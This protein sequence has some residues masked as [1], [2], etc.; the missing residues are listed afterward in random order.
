[1]MHLRVFYAILGKPGLPKLP[2]EVI[3]TILEN[4]TQSF[5]FIRI[6]KI[7][8]DLPAQR[9]VH[10]ISKPVKIWSSTDESTA[11][12]QD[13]PQTFQYDITRYRQVF[14]YFRKEDKVEFGEKWRLGF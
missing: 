14:D 9:H 6:L 5:F 7:V 11:G 12:P 2:I 13:L 3:A 4:M 8:K 1:M 10:Y